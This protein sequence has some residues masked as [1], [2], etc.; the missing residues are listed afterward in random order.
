MMYHWV[1][2]VFH[3]FIVFKNNC[4]VFVQLS[5]CLAI[6]FS[7][8][9]V[10]LYQYSSSAFIQLGAEFIKIEISQRDGCTFLPS[11]CSLFTVE[12]TRQLWYFFVQFAVWFRGWT[13]FVFRPTIFLLHHWIRTTLD[14]W[15]LSYSLLETSCHACFLVWVTDYRVFIYMHLWS[16]PVVFT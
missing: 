1:I 10:R 9:T 3:C 14:L 4:F 2:K 15:S 11:F 7:C 5:F 6:V 16:V 8:D 12:D 13:G